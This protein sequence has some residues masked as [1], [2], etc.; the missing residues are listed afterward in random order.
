MAAKLQAEHGDTVSL[1]AAVVSVSAKEGTDVQ[2]VSAALEPLLDE[3][4][5]AGLSAAHFR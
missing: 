3:D 2:D 5:E 4:R 1:P